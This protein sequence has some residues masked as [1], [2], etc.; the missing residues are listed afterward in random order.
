[1]FTHTIQTV[2]YK[3]IKGLINQRITSLCVQRS[4]TVFDGKS[5]HLSVKTI[6]CSVCVHQTKDLPPPCSD[7]V[8]SVQSVWK[9]PHLLQVSIC[10]RSIKFHLSA[11]S[12]PT[13]LSLSTPGLNLEC[14]CGESCLC[15]S[16]RLSRAHDSERLQV[17][18][19]GL[20]PADY[21]TLR[22]HVCQP[23]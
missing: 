21:E 10:S 15:P 23:R 2:R 12:H 3:T 7:A 4:Q 5:L 19:P 1:M 18:F 11:H 17:S 8:S 22:L 13:D 16:L 20:V 9:S 6:T 14:M